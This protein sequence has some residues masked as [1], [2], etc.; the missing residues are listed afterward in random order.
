M[1]GKFL[2]IVQTDYVDL[3][4][5]LRFS[6]NNMIQFLGFRLEEKP[7]ESHENT[8]NEDVEYVEGEDGDDDSV[9]F[10]DEGK[11]YKNPRNSPTPLC[12]RDEEQAALLVGI[13]LNAI[14]NVIRF[15]NNHE[16]FFLF[17][18]RVRSV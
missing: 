9:I 8:T 6:F 12:P 13:R 5:G 1:P 7:I 17:L 2:I 15:S 14:T 11:I 3:Y 10:D 16:L 4:Q 18:S